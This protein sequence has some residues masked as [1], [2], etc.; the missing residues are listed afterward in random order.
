MLF[1]STIVNI[2]T[3]LNSSRTFNYG[4]YLQTAFIYTTQVYANLTHGILVIGYIFMKHN[5]FYLQ[6]IFCFQL[7]L[8]QPGN[9]IAG[10]L[11]T[12]PFAVNYVK[13]SALHTGNSYPKFKPHIPSYL[14]SC[15]LYTL[16]FTP[17]QLLIIYY[18]YNIRLPCTMKY[19]HQFSLS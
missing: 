17:L 3:S 6:T 9:K 5:L 12:F 19:R 1:I 15:L 10:V 7:Q 18:S 11:P 14:L 8:G 4:N 13:L 16:D 2:S